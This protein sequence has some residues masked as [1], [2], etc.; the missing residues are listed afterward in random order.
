MKNKLYSLILIIL[1]TIN[2]GFCSQARTVAVNDLMI[3]FVIAMAGVLLASV[4]IWVG[5]AIYNKI[6][7]RG[8]KPLTPEEEA[9]KTPKTIDEAVKFFISK[10]RLQ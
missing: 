3:R 1:L 2:A 8:R 7:V 4:A 9:L 5:L 6:L 10:N